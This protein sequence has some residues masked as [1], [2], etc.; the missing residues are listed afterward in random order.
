MVDPDTDNGGVLDGA[1]DFDND[2]KYESTAGE[3]NPLDPSDDVNITICDEDHPDCG[4]ENSGKICDTGTSL[5]VEGCKDV[6]GSGCPDGQICIFPDPAVDVGYCGNG[7]TGGGPGGPG[8]IPYDGCICGVPSGG[9][10][11][12]LG[13]AVVVFAALAAWRRRRGPRF[14]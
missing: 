5:C 13:W 9:G 4:P 12:D 8:T 14:N 10:E 11:R 3:G 2:G 7:N 1:E 6:E